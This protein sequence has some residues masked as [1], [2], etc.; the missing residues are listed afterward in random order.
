MRQLFGP[1][2]F[3][4]VRRGRAAAPATATPSRSTPRFTSTSSPRSIRCC[5]EA[6]P[7][8]TVRWFQRGSEDVAARLNSEIAAGRVGA[9]LVMTSDPFWYQ[10]LKEAGHLLEYRSP[11]RR[12]IPP[13]LNDPDGTFVTV[14]VPVMVLAVNTTRVAAGARPR[15]FRELAE[16]AWAGRVTMGDPE[17]V[18]L[19][20][21]GRR[22]ARARSTGGS[23]S[24]RSARNDI[25]A[26]GGNSAVLS[27]VM[28]GEKDAGIILLENL[29]QARE[30]NPEAPIEIVYPEDGAILVPSPI[31][32]M[33]A[34][35]ARGC[36]AS[37]LRL[38][39]VGRRPGGDRQRLDVFA[40]RHTFQPRRRA[41][42][43]RG[44]LGAA[45]AL[46]VRLPARDDQRARRDQAAVQQRRARRRM[47]GRWLAGPAAGCPDARADCA[48]A[49]PLGRDAG[50]RDAAALRA[51]RSASRRTCRRSSTRSSSHPPRSSSPPRLRFRWPGS[52]R[53]PI[54]R[55]APLP[56][57]PRR[58]LR[59]PALSRRDRVDQPREPDGWLAEP[60]RR[61]GTIFDIY[62]TAG[63]HLGARALL[64][65]LRVSEC[66]AALENIDPSLEDA[67]RMSG[68]GP[69]T[70]LRDD[71]AA[72]HLARD[73]GRRV[74]RLCGVG[75][76]VR[77][78]GADRLASAALQLLTTRIYGYATHGRPRR[79]LHRRRAL[80][81]ALL[82][83]ALVDV[84]A[85]G[86][87]RPRR[88][89]HERHGQGV[90]PVAASRSALALAA[91][92]RGDRCR[93]S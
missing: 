7:D 70:V 58:A 39:P 86:P 10:E 72:A 69:L 13:A 37:A 36:G 71:H 27:R 9:D 79:P 53:E 87:A 4:S 61:R 59:R 50:G 5:E 33:K 65:H 76:R 54:C 88:P 56:R 68:A 2:R 24:T 66:L 18:R 30:Q 77:R 89:H 67:A 49:R 82:V 28:T 85:G 45:P 40:A 26:A 23:T 35:A 3:P 38:L 48:G 11:G 75:L 21:H 64:L 55:R 83:I 25:V 60:S 20:V 16:P 43:A 93:R 51:R 62:T 12:R 19:G 63:H 8:L 42:V 15:T 1:G 17:S 29:L 78:A 91:L 34:T 74:P 22:G 80:S 84:D 92:R 14:R 32:I 31:A 81:A 90:H 57:A 73:P 41:P 6:F 52:W 46:D 47:T 44:L